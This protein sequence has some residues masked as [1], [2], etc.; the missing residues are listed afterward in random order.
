MET[1]NIIAEV[2]LNQILYDM[3]HP[4]YSD[5][6]IKKRIWQSLAEKLSFAGGA[7]EM[8]KKWY[9]LRT[10][11]L[12]NKKKLPSGSAVK[13]EKKWPY[14]DEMQFIDPFIKDRD[15]RTSNL[16]DTLS[17]WQDDSTAGETVTVI[18]EE[19]DRDYSDSQG[20]LSQSAVETPLPLYDSALPLPLLSSPT[21]IVL[22]PPTLTPSTI[23]DRNRNRKRQ[24]A[25]EKALEDDVISNRLVMAIEAGAAALAQ[26]IPSVE[27][28]LNEK[29]GQVIAAELSHL[30]DYQQ[31][32]FKQQ[33]FSLLLNVRFPQQGQTTAPAHTQDISYSNL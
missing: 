26:P 12:R 5:C 20:K 27:L 4:S 32:Y 25:S 17:S 23:R 7:I 9:S 11:Y 28:S 18:T 21:A 29:F 33:I 24:R 19:D 6:Y 8:K 1:S 22:R 15:E 14:F 2:R 31:A 3:S 13:A 30:T 16:S 10:T